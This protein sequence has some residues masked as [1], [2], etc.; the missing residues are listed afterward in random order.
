MAL[1]SG[2]AAALSGLAAPAAVRSLGMTAA[3]AGDPELV[4][5]LHGVRYLICCI[6]WPIDR[7]ALL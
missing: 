2:V 5:P 7:I 3:E 1:L 6:D 4:R